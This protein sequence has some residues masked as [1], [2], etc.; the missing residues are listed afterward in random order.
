[1]IDTLCHTWDLA[2]AVNASESLDEAAVAIAYEKLKEMGD[3]IRVPGGF[4]DAITPLP[5]AD[6]QT[7]F[8]NFTGRAV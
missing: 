5:S 4:K 8:L 1:M 7:Q 6:F 2:R 3:A